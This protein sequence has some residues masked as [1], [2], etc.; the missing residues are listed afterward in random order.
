MASTISYSLMRARIAIALH[1]AAL[2]VALLRV[3]KP[4]AVQL[5]SSGKQG[6][7]CHRVAR[8]MAA[9]FMH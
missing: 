4:K 7:L 2:A 6:C 8:C 3:S 9:D 1:K 5:L